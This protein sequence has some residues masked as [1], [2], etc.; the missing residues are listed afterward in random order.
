[1]SYL[2]HMMVV[3]VETVIT[4]LG[5]VLLATTSLLA[6]TLMQMLFYIINPLVV[7]LRAKYY[8]FSSQI[9]LFT[10]IKFILR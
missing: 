6:N 1:M 7:V 9:Y 2:L 4:L 10:C 3:S 5:I 8:V